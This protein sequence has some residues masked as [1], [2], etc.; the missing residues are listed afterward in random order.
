[1]TLREI[2]LKAKG[3][4]PYYNQYTKIDLI[5]EIQNQEGNIPC[6]K[7]DKCCDRYECT[8]WSDCME[9]SRTNN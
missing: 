9:T 1:M 2:R 8:W 4:V 7:T 5:R 3:L 6:F